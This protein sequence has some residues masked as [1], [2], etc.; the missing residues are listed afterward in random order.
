[1]KEDFSTY[2]GGSGIDNAIGIALDSQDNI[3][4]TGLTSSRDFPT[5][6]AFQPAH[7]GGS[8]L[9]GIDAYVA[10]LSRDGSKLMYSTFLGGTGHDSGFGIAVDSERCALITGSTGS[11]DF[12]IKNADPASFWRWRT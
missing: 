1:M 11:P 4:I 8:F 9:G 5:V 3:Y 6:N 7:G 2:F 10:K 12:P